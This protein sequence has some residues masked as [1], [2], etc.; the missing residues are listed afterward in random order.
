MYY[1]PLKGG[2]R[3]IFDGPR[4]WHNVLGTSTASLGVGLWSTDTTISPI[5]R[6]NSDDQYRYRVSSRCKPRSVVRGVPARMYRFITDKRG[7]RSAGIITP[8]DAY[9]IR[10]NSVVILPHALVC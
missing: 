7:S 10:G 3:G 4:R 2:K 5:P 9:S 6:S 8:V 1:V